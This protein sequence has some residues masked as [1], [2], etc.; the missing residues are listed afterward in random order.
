[1]LTCWTATSYEA[2][3]NSYYIT[4]HFGTNALYN[5]PLSPPAIGQVVPPLSYK[6]DFGTKEDWYVI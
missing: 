6:D 3:S 2:S 1:M 4:P 5:T